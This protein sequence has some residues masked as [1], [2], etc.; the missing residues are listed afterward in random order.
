LAVYPIDPTGSVQYWGGPTDITLSTTW[1]YVYHP[2]AFQPLHVEALAMFGFPSGSRFTTTSFIQQGAPG[3]ADGVT[4]V[5]N[6]YGHDTL[7]DGCLFGWED[8]PAAPFCLYMRP[9]FAGGHTAGGTTIQNSALMMGSG[10][11]I[12]NQNASEGYEHAVY[13]DCFDYDTGDPLTL[14]D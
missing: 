1:C 5:T 7:F 14:P 3:Y 12:Y 13:I 11:Y 8:G 2:V 4:G 6:C 9:D 10:M